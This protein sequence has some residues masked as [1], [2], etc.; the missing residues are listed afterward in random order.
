MPLKS[1]IALYEPSI[2]ESSRYFSLKLKQDLNIEPTEFQKQKKILAITNIQG[3]FQ[4]LRRLL[5]QLGIMD[6]TYH[7]IF[8]EGHLII[9][10]N[11]SGENEIATECLWLI[12]ALEEK[13]KRCGG[14]IHFIIGKNELKN[15]NGKWQH[16]QPRYVNNPQ[17][18]KAPYVVLYDGN[19]ELRRWLQT[20]N[21]IEKI[22]DILISN[23]DISIEILNIHSSLSEL[24]S[25]ARQHYA[26][27]N[28]FHINPILSKMLHG[29]TPVLLEN[30]YFQPIDMQEETNGAC[31][32]FIMKSIMDHTYLFTDSDRTIYNNAPSMDQIDV[33]LI[34][35]DRVYRVNR[36]GKRE[37]L[38]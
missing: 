12:Y 37:K 4:F 27:V 18:S 33:L 30:R 24:N 2:K 36:V 31:Y 28:K 34:K 10:G 1:R 35:E 20:K 38:V 11:C 8:G 25:Y 6:K 5:V 13:A 21:V 17:T 16:E 7:W 22:G 32:K 29:E 19:R 3:D 9:A 23:T 14:Y 15:I 26:Q